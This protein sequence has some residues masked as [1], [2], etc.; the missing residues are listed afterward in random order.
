MEGRIHEIYKSLSGEGI[1]TGIPT[2]FVRLAGC[3]LRCG[4]TEGGRRLWCDTPYALSPNAGDLISPSMVMDRIIALQT[5][6]PAQVLITGGEPLAGKNR[7]LTYFLA[8][9]CSTICTNPNHP[10]PRIETNGAELLTYSSGDSFAEFQAKSP[11]DPKESNESGAKSFSSPFSTENVPDT[12]TAN[13]VFTLDYKLPGSGMEDRM[14]LENLSLL[15]ERNHPLDELKFVVR[16]RRDFERSLEILQEHDPLTW[17]LYSPVTG[18]V[19]PQE[20]AEWVKEVPHPKARL[21]LQMHKIL[22]G[23][24]RGV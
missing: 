6:S 12:A 15:R 17:I 4:Q 10:L 8:K 2:I 20:L 13:L 1:T 21:S 23:E 16:D 9:H 18:E 5:D 24:K 7:D 19:A 11:T 14:R 22:W 3:S